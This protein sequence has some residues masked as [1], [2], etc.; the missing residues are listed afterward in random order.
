MT[1]KSFLEG[2]IQAGPPLKPLFV[3]AKTY[4]SILSLF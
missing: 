3:D 2:L 4:L 1:A